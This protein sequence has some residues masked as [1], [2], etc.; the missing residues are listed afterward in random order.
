[1]ISRRRL[2]TAAAPLLGLGLLGCAPTG[3]TPATSQAGP[4]GST[5]E[6]DKPV[7]LN[8]DRIFNAEWE[9]HQKTFMSWPNR[10]IWGKDLAYVRD[11]IA[12][13]ARAITQFE[14]VVMLARPGEEA[15][16]RYQCGSGVTVLTLGVD[17]LWSRDTVPVF[18]NGAGG[19][20]GV[21]FNFNGWGNKQ[22][23]GNDGGVA[24]ALLAA[25]GMPR[26]ETPI[27]AE[28]GSLETDGQGTLL[29]TKS[30][31]LNDNRN[32]GMSLEQL[33][34]GLKDLLGVSKVIWF[35][36]VYGQDI[37]DAHVDSLARFTAPGKVLLD[38][39]GEGAPVD[40]WS[41]SSEQARSLLQDSRDANGRAFEII[42]LPQPD[43]SKIRGQDDD[44]L[45]S[46]VNFYV[47]NGAVL[48]P[49]FG[50]KKADQRAQGILQDHFPG[51]KVIALDID[52]IASGGGG[53]HCAT[54]DLPVVAA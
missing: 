31:M 14:E 52:T 46:Y 51:R 47:A 50:D 5:N 22:Q 11:D 16:A 1:M 27:V 20:R 26:I 35:D 18:V 12:K 36:G 25:L 9:T 19:L 29:V 40:D 48:L 23:H 17:D 42:D 54:H 43:F 32:P 15:E 49:Q 4:A 53:I 10:Q 37:T 44:F 2:L 34:A 3:S 7:K 30:S 39:P 45:A 38:V 28:A 8:P 24:K 6:T 13:V 41:R 21:D 33:D